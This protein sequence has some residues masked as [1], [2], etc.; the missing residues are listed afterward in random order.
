[1]L[2]CIAGL[3]PRSLHNPQVAL[4]SVATTDL[5]TELA[6]RRCRRPS[7]SR[8][9]F[10]RHP[11]LGGIRYVALKMSTCRFADADE[12]PPKSAAAPANDFGYWRVAFIFAGAICPH[13]IETASSS[14][15]PAKCKA[16]WRANSDHSLILKY[17]A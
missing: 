15:R 8:S 10:G 7:A 3:Y 12:P 9:S 13:T 5:L 4:V 1:M 16:V 17:L 6:R 14:N 2:L 11:D